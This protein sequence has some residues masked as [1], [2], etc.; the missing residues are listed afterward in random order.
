[1][2]LGYD[3][4]VFS[5]NSQKLAMLK[6]SRYLVGVKGRKEHGFWEGMCGGKGEEGRKRGALMTEA[7]PFLSNLLPFWATVSVSLGTGFGLFR[8]HTRQLP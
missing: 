5:L 2:L 1:M 7:V 8:I 3:P 4:V 6:W